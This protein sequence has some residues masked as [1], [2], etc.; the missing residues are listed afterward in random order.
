MLMLPQGEHTIEYT[1]GD[2]EQLNLS[3]EIWHVA[4]PSQGA[5][6]SLPSPARVMQKEPSG[7][8]RACAPLISHGRGMPTHVA[9]GNGAAGASGAGSQHH[10]STDGDGPGGLLAPEQQGLRSWMPSMLEVMPGKRLAEGVQ[11]EDQHHGNEA[12]YVHSTAVGPG[13]FSTFR[14]LGKLQEAPRTERGQRKLQQAQTGLGQEDMPGGGENIKALHGQPDPMTASNDGQ[15]SGGSMSL[16]A[17]NPALSPVRYVLQIS[18]DM[19]QAKKTIS[20]LV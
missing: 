11:V 15:S 13:A 18:S 8:S 4:N 10:E 16:A 2:I 5:A 1:D 20:A 12:A 3:Q 7:P 14:H 17:V 6:T 19:R 9:P